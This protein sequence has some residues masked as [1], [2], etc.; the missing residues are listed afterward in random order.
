[1]IKFYGFYDA[2]HVCVDRYRIASSSVICVQRILVMSICHVYN[3]HLLLI[4]EWLTF[5]TSL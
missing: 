2:E 1:V 3:G 5:Y 4:C